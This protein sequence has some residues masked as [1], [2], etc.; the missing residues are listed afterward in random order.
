[1]RLSRPAIDRR[2]DGRTLLDRF[3]ASPAAADDDDLGLEA[4]A[5]QTALGADILLYVV[6]ALSEPMPK[7]GA[8]LWV[9]AAT[10]RPVI[11][12]L[13]YTAHPDAQPDRWRSICADESVHTTV[14]FDAVVYDD[15][16]EQRFGL[17]R[18]WWTPDKRR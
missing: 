12:V 1:M 17:A 13:N 16:G 2:D 7:H 11:P 6:D 9:L 4:K 10:T 18:V 8:E 3:L 15:A 14:E 5:V